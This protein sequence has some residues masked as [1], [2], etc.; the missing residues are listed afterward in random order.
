VSELVAVLLALIVAATGITRDVD[1]ELTA[2]AEQRAIEVSCDGCFS[3]AGGVAG[4]WEV[5]AWNSGFTDPAG[6][7]LDQWRSSPSH[8][9][10]LT[11]PT[12]THIGCGH[13]QVAERHYFA[14]VLAIDPGPNSGGG[15]S[16][17]SSAPSTSATPPPAPVSLLPNT[18]ARP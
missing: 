6:K 4:T 7:A 18:A 3:H 17:P 15:A 11:D 10:T 5:L 13:H 14:C 2:I 9:A 8:W 16:D 1:A 12:L